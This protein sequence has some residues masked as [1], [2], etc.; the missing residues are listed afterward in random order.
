M[1]GSV[2]LPCVSSFD[3]F[4]L[5]F[6]AG[7][8]LNSCTEMKQDHHL[9]TSFVNYIKDGEWMDNL[10]ENDND[11]S[12]PNEFLLNKYSFNDNDVSTMKA[13]ISKR[14]ISNVS[15]LTHDFSLLSLGEE[16]LPL[17]MKLFSSKV[18]CRAMLLCILCSLYFKSPTYRISSNLS[19]TAAEFLFN[20]ATM[21][22]SDDL[23][24]YLANPNSSFVN[25][26]HDIL[27]KLPY[28]IIVSTTTSNDSSMIKYS[29]RNDGIIGQ[30]LHEKYIPNRVMLN[31]NNFEKM[32][33]QRGD[34]RAVSVED[35]DVTLLAH[36]PLYD[37]NNMH[38]NTIFLESNTLELPMYMSVEERD[39]ELLE[40]VNQLE[41]LLSLLYVLI[42][43]EPSP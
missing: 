22:D 3:G 11:S 28:H 8:L 2:G 6:S 17:N 19:T 36:V 4:N 7:F 25:D 20:V 21:F 10:I 31:Y 24:A 23:I 1:G 39:I 40:H 42:G 32:L 34:Y 15:E 13:S 38:I 5:I 14:R 30:N 26:L 18:N 29:N 16:E 33:F 37:N 12:F 9:R 43:C 27:L 35:R 41:V